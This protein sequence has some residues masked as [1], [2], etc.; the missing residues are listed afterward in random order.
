MIKHLFS[1]RIPFLQLLIVLNI[2]YSYS[3]RSERP[4]S[5]S[6]ALAA[7]GEKEISEYDGFQFRLI[8][9]DS[10][11]KVVAIRI[12]RE[13]NGLFRMKIGR[14]DRQTRSVEISGLLIINEL[15]F[16]YFVHLV[17]DVEDKNF[18]EIRGEVAERLAILDGV[19]YIFEWTDES[20]TRNFTM[21]DFESA[22]EISSDAFLERFGIDRLVAKN[23]IEAVDFIF[24]VA[25]LKKAREF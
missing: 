17:K 15:E 10:L 18:P 1:S 7:M 20:D 19:D 25:G 24:D 3:A 2:F 4:V 11:S 16:M 9:N 14:F 6:E 8:R 5:I 23:W 13:A 12:F 22:G 21:Q